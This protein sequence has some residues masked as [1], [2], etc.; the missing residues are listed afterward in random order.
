MKQDYKEKLK[1]RRWH[2]K[3]SKIKH[4]DEY[5]CIDCGLNFLRKEKQLDVHH[6]YYD[7]SKDIDDYEDKNLITLCHSCHDKEHDIDKTLYDKAKK[8]IYSLKKEGLLASQ[9]DSLFDGLIDTSKNNWTLV[10]L[11]EQ[12]KHFNYNYARIRMRPI[13]HNVVKREDSEIEIWK[14]ICKINKVDFDKDKIG[15]GAYQNMWD[16]YYNDDNE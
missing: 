12:F 3:A 8:Y 6:T 1:S 15:T 10:S 14:R 11:K 5:E 4:L 9:I 16:N 13:R 7:M 2:D